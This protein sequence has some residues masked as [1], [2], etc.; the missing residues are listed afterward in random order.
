VSE[1][2]GC[3]GTVSVSLP[4]RLVR[5]C[6][7]A[8]RRALLPLR[9]ASLRLHPPDRLARIGREH[10]IEA[11]RRRAWLLSGTFAAGEGTYFNWHVSAV[12]TRWGERAA[13]LGERVALA[14]GVTFVAS[15]GPCYS[16]LA[17]LPGFAERHIKYAPITV[18]DDTWLGANVTILPGV[19][20][21]RCCLVGAG[22][23]V[24]KDVPDYAV[25]AG[26]PARVLGDVRSPETPPT[27][28]GPAT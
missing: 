11:V 18:G 22:S 1:T 24:T 16:R 15:S 2:P 19:R 5:F 9:L 17:Q 26:V 21:G 8:L 10:H 13:T 4:R 14:P 23:V 28:Q 7:K 27:P 3:C 6:R 25:A 12:V 20:I